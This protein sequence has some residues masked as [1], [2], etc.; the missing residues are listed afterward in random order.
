MIPGK[1]KLIFLLLLLNYFTATLADE[2]SRAFPPV[3]IENSD[4]NSKKKKY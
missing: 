2:K 3:I 4:S 1:I